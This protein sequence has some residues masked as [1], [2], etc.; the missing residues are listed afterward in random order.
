[1]VNTFGGTVHK[2]QTVITPKIDSRRNI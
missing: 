1:M 2:Q